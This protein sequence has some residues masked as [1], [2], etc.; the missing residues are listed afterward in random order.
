MLPIEAFADAV[1]FLHLYDLKALLFANATCATLA[2]KF[3]WEDLSELYFYV[4]SRYE[5]PLEIARMRSE[6]PVT[7][8]G[9]PN[10]DALL[11]FVAAAFPNCVINGL[12]FE[13]PANRR[14][15]DAIGDVADSIVITD[16]LFSG[17]TPCNTKKSPRSSE[18]FEALKR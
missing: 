13:Y 4:W 11:E 5:E 1:A 2:A 14:V 7:R 15:L 16:R 9:F 8:F 12:A 10:E 17:L 18:G 6:T 3:R